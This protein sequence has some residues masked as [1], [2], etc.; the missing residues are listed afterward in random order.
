MPPLRRSLRL[1]GLHADPVDT[2]GPPPR[3]KQSAPKANKKKP[4]DSTL[5]PDSLPRTIETQLLLCNNYTTILGVD[6][7]GRGPLAGPVVAAAAYVPQILPGIVDSKRTKDEATR[8]ALYEALVASEGIRWAVAV[9][10]APRIDEINILQATMQAMSMA[11]NA[12][13]EPESVVVLPEASVEQQGCYVV[14]P[15][16][17]TTLS[18]DKTYA[19]ID[20][21]RVPN[22]L[23]CAAQAV[24]R[25]DSKEYAIASASILAKVTRDRLMNAYD[26]LYPEYNLK[27]H[28]GYP[29]QAHMEAV[30]QWGATPIHRRTFAPLKHMTL[31]AQGR[32]VEEER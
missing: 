12:L 16:K 11:V 19:L 13:V 7:A 18:K 3:K 25:G 26:T 21:N 27:Q 1:R 17:A 10:D 30:K 28:K 24:V 2:N 9:V 23:P 5:P 14:C 32:V 31:D 29:T 22:D 8:E 4:N 6:E 20:G 15:R